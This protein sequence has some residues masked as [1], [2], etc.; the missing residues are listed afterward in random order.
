MIYITTKQTTLVLIALSTNHSYPRKEKSLYASL[1]HILYFLQN[2]SPK[3]LKSILIISDAVSSGL[4]NSEEHASHDY[5]RRIARELCLVVVIQVGS[6]N[7]FYPAV[8][9]GHVPDPEYLRLIALATGG[10]YLELI[11]S[12]FYIHFHSF[13][14][15]LFFI[16][17]SSSLYPFYL[18]IHSSFLILDIICFL[19]IFILID[20]LGQF[21]YSTD[22]H[23]ITNE[24]NNESGPNLYHNQFLIRK[25]ILDKNIN[26]NLWKSSE[27]YCDTRLVDTPVVHLSNLK[28]DEKDVVEQLKSAYNEPESERFPWSLQ[29]TPP[30]TTLLLYGLFEYTLQE[31]SLQSVIAARLKEGYILHSIRIKNNSKK[32]NKSEKVNIIFILPW[33]SNITLFYKISCYKSQLSATNDQSKPPRIEL[34]M[35]APTTFTLLLMNLK[36]IQS[37]PYSLTESSKLPIFDSVLRLQEYVHGIYDS[38][39]HF[40]SIHLHMQRTLSDEST[41]LSSFC[42]IDQI[43]SSKV[44]SFDEDILTIILR[45]TWFNSQGHS[46]AQSPMDSNSTLNRQVATDC[47]ITYFTAWSTHQ[48]DSLTF[49]KVLPS[50]EMIHVKL[51]FENESVLTITLTSINT[52]RNMRLEELELITTSLNQINHIYGGTL[53]FPIIVCNKMM[54]QFIYGPNGHRIPNINC[55]GP[56]KKWKF[57][58]NLYTNEIFNET[59]K[60]L[61]SFHR[62]S[63]G[64]LPIFESTKKTVFYMEHT[65]DADR[66]GNTIICISLFSIINDYSNGLFET[67]LWVEPIYTLK[68]EAHLD[69][70]VESTLFSDVYE[71]FSDVLLGSIELRDQDVV[72]LLFTY[73]WIRNQILNPIQVDNISTMEFEEDPVDSVYSKV[74]VKQL[75]GYGQIFVSKYKG[76]S[77]ETFDVFSTLFLKCIHHIMD[78]E[79][80]DL[81]LFEEV[82][83]IFSALNDQ[84]TTYKNIAV[85]GLI[86]YFGKIIDHD[87]FLILAVSDNSDDLNMHGIVTCYSFI[88]KLPSASP[89][90]VFQQSQRAFQKFHIEES[91]YFQVKSMPFISEKYYNFISLEGTFRYDA[92]RKDFDIREVMNSLR[93][94]FH[95]SMLQISYFALIEEQ[96]ISA[97]LCRSAIDASNHLRINMDISD[98]LRLTPIDSRY[99]IS[100]I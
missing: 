43:I 75:L 95:K 92:N 61:I 78:I 32:P 16:N 7:G 68:N 11:Q 81:T 18:F 84:S 58:T 46:D 2:A 91:N 80:Q 97:E 37:N 40:K 74:N 83:S 27:L 64:Y 26:D 48:F 17:I 89:K 51:T 86:R 24:E 15:S 30:K 31:S 8:N 96:K 45:S 49:F 87:T 41:T 10:T 34:N 54:H 25:L 100:V 4:L 82:S 5:C 56:N 93:I 90:S 79:L 47:L 38:D 71:L 3:R 66:S 29:S 67:N 63:E 53:F 85:S 60:Q 13:E 98:F 62:L 35:L 44:L 36:K 22:C 52:S 14:Y 33:L 73:D 21:M 12:S 23:Y 69:F 20:E 70:I 50:F 9:F 39:S 65:L 88:C 19:F 28:G 6:P 72:D 42:G 59:L 94:C 76:P 77:G 55:Y 1:N 99:S 57:F